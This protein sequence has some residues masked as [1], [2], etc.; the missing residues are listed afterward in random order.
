[1]FS[2][3]SQRMLGRRAAGRSAAGELVTVPRNT[4]ATPRNTTAI[5]L[6]V[7][8]IVTLSGWDLQG[9]QL[10]RTQKQNEGQCTTW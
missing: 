6:L 3:T 5:G 10:P 8:F 2:P 9:A 1:M 7:E 4:V